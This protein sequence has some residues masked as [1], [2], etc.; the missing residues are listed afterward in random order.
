MVTPTATRTMGNGES[1]RPAGS[2]V[3]SS[4]RLVIGCELAL[5]AIVAGRVI[6]A[7]IAMRRIALTPFQFDYGEGNVLATLVRIVHG[8]TPYPDPRAFPNAI[9]PY[10]PVGYYLLA[11]P[12]R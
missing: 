12:V 5:A 1:A 7:A 2:G 9:D 3:R 8:L 4:G 6:D 11:I 10:G